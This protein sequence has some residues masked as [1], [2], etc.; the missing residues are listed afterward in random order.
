MFH[1]R[2]R[3]HVKFLNMYMYFRDCLPLDGNSY[4]PLHRAT[5][6]DVFLVYRVRSSYLMKSYTISV[7]KCTTFL[8]LLLSP[9]LALKMSPSDFSSN[10]LSLITFTGKHKKPIKSTQKHWT[11]PTQM[12]NQLQ[13]FHVWTGRL[14]SQ[15]T[16]HDQLQETSYLILLRLQS[17]RM[18]CN[19]PTNSSSFINPSCTETP[20][21]RAKQL[22]TII[23][24]VGAFRHLF[25]RLPLLNP[26]AADLGRKNDRN[27]TLV[28]NSHSLFANQHTQL[29]PLKEGLFGLC[30]IF[31]TMV[32][33]WSYLI[34]L[35]LGLGL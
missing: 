23:D 29:P 15:Q 14:N 35:F 20:S 17:M 2:I 28:W 12:P 32:T 6:L 22:I 10:K 26:T 13:P 18:A 27:W 24:F 30:T 4:L 7:Y 16:A 25:L 8:K 1:T 11:F 21:N 5:F 34:G 31:M 33:Y 3:F 9:W 19:S